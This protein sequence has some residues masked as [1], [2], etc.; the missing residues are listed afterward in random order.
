MFPNELAPNVPNNIPRNLHFCSFAL[1]YI[2]SLT[3]SISNPESSRD[4]TILIMSSISSFDIF[5]VIVPRPKSFFYIPASG[6]DAAVVDSND[7][8]QFYLIV[9]AYFS[10]MVN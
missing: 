3:P 4:L 7:I 1:F 8:K 5:S 9:E 6:A 2:V 10:L